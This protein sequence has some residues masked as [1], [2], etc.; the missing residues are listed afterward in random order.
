MSA[1]LRVRRQYQII[2]LPGHIY[3]QVD[4]LTNLYNPYL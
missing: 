2:N 3:V 1:T 4:W